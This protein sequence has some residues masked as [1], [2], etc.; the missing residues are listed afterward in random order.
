MEPLVK[1]RIK[2]HYKW[3]PFL[4]NNTRCKPLDNR[5]P[6]SF[7]I[8]SLSASTYISSTLLIFC[9]AWFEP[10][11]GEV[12][13][14]PYFNLAQ[15]RRI[16]ASATCGESP[17]GLPERETYCNLVGA[18]TDTDDAQNVIGGQVGYY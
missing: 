6:N 4:H 2:D 9:I 5:K 3:P 7:K 10:S 16:Q 18:T 12:L 13:T 8:L 11:L 17:D 14:P 1:K 15:G